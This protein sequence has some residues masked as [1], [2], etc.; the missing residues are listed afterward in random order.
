MTGSVHV[1]EVLRDHCSLKGA[2][3]FAVGLCD[4]S[5]VK[6]LF[7]TVGFSPIAVGVGNSGGMG[8]SS[9]WDGG[10]VSG[11]LRRLLQGEPVSFSGCLCLSFPQY[12]L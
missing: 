8:E 10:T 11:M 6:I 3:V 4:I 2:D 7:I 9:C 1:R 5:T 12:L